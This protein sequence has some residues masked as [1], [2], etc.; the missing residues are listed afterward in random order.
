MSRALLGIVVSGHG[1]ASE[2]RHL[3]SCNGLECTRYTGGFDPVARFP[4]A[5]LS[6]A[7]LRS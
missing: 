6:L 5:G 3:F 1:H 2:C 7:V 4:S